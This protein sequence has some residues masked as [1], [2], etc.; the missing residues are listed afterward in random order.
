[1]ADR[2]ERE[3]ERSQRTEPQLVLLGH[4]AFCWRSPCRHKRSHRSHVIRVLR[5]EP[6]KNKGRFSL[7][8]PRVAKQGDNRGTGHMHRFR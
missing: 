7:F 6:E 8:S 5:G 3:A 1:M 2:R 4:S